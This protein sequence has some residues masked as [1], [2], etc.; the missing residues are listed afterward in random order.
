MLARGTLMTS[1][2]A[3]WQRGHFPRNI[4]SRLCATND[5]RTMS[6]QTSRTVAPREQVAANDPPCVLEKDT[7]CAAWGGAQ[8][9]LS[10][11][12][13]LSFPA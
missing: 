10:L 5:W 6:R 11:E 9:V 4:A 13:Q 3:I 7:G 8:E 12:A 1:L 2:S